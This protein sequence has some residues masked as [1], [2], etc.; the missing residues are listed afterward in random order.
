MT[1]AAENS[2]AATAEARLLVE[3]ECTLSAQLGAV[4]SDRLDQAAEHAQTVESLLKTLRAAGLSPAGRSALAR[5]R[6]SHEQIA[7]ALRQQQA[8]LK[9]DLARVRSGKTM[10]KTYRQNTP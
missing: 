4:T 8:E 6:R 3:L 10:L 5:A 9:Q 1:S 2:A 7:L